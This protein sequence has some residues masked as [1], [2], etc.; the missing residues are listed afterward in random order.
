MGHFFKE[1][2]DKVISALSLIILFPLMIILGIMVTFSSA[3]PVIFKQQRVGKNGRLFNIFK[4]RTMYHHISK[5]SFSIKGDPRI[6]PVGSFLRKWKMDELPELWNVLKGDM[7][8]VGP[9]PYIPEMASRL[10]ENEKKVL[11]FKPGMTGPASLKY[12]NEEEILADVED[13]VRYNNEVI[14]PDK[15]KINL[16]YFDNWNFGKDIRILWYTLIRKQVE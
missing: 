3:G 4:F 8:L 2:L 10:T 9:R 7:S 6:T 11:K 14:F 15:V 13:P 12:I 16:D 5:N 1:V